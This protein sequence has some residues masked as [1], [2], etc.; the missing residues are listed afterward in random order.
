[1]V[2]S[3]SQGFQYL[4]LG[5]TFLNLNPYIATHLWAIVSTPTPEDQVVMFNFTSRKPGCDETCVIRRGEHPFVKHDTAVAYR[6]GRLLSRTDWNKLQEL[7]FY[8]AQPPLSNALLKRIQQGALDSEFTP[9][10]LQEI[11]RACMQP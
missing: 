9:I 4:N 3:R 1:V 7:G 11:V 2:F 5:D 8:E 10:G 6:R